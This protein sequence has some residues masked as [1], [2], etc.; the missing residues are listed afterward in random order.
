MRFV[1][2]IQDP[3]RPSNKRVVMM[4]IEDITEDDRKMFTQLGYPP[5]D[6]GGDSEAVN[7]SMWKGYAVMRAFDS[8]TDAQGHI[9]NVAMLFKASVARLKERWKHGGFTGTT[10]TAEA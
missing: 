3:L 7:L 4:V 9:D 10:T 1:G 8:P 2:T 5:I 6:F